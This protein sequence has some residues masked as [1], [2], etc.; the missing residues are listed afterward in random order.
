[1]PPTADVP[2]RELA[3]PPGVTP[4]VIEIPVRFSDVDGMQHVNNVVYLTYTE[5]ARTRWAIEDLDS[6]SLADITFILAHAEI[7][8]LAAA[9]LGDTVRVEMWVPRIGTKSWDFA[10][11]LTDATGKRLFAVARTTQVAYDYENEKTIPLS[12]RYLDGLKP[13]SG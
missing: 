9:N 10:Y 1:M 3:P 5:E 13:M 7:D 12:E 6:E 2:L 8:F 11:R 4:R